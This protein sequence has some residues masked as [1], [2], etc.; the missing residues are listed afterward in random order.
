MQQLERHAFKRLGNMRVD[1]IG[2]EDV[3]AVLDSYLDK[4]TGNGAARSA[5]AYQA[6]TMLGAQANGYIE[7]NFA[8]EVIRRCA[9]PVH[10][11]CQSKTCDH[12]PYADGS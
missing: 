3:L 2:R 5:G 7:T 11:S 8:G 4:Q 10:A 1:K 9:L 12:L 6:N